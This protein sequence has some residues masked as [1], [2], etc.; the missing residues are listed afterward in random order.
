MAPL[1]FPRYQLVLFVLFLTVKISAQTWVQVASMPN[2]NERYNAV[3]FAIGNKGYVTTGQTTNT[4]LNTTWEYDPVTD[5]WTQMANFPGGN[6]RV[7][8]GFAIGNKGYVLCG[9][10][11]S[12]SSGALHNDVWEFDPAAN[13]WT[14]KAN[15][16]GG[17]RENLVAFSIGGNGYA[18]LG[19]NGSRKLDFYKYDPVGDSWTQLPDIDYYSHHYNTTV[20]VLNGKGYFA[21]GSAYSSATFSNYTSNKVYMFD[22]ATGIWTE[23]NNF[24]G[25]ARQYGT[26]FTANGKAFMG[27]GNNGLFLTDLWQYDEASDTWASAPEFTPGGRIYT[28]T[29]T[30]GDHVYVGNGRAPNSQTLTSFYTLDTS[31]SVPVAALQSFQVVSGH[32]TITIAPNIP[33]NCTVK[34]F[35]S[36]GK[37]AMSRELEDG[38]VQS[39]IYHQL[40]PGVYVLSIFGSGKFMNR[41]FVVAD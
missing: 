29:F 6:R 5:A 15:F 28:S 11:D 24:A 32:E 1:T 4:T 13:T 20:F 31:L 17:N 25:T 19:L 30:V 41:K 2:F 22:P 10:D 33:G 7:A 12:S 3:S 14:Q 37:L 8:A 38:R 23:K 27:M 34:I 18:G 36:D 9:R 40:N 35:T 39:T 16:P 21:T 26:A